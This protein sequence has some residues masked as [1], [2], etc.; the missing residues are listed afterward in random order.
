MNDWNKNW[1][2]IYYK[3]LQEMSIE[4]MIWRNELVGNFCSIR[5]RFSEGE[6]KIFQG[7]LAH[8]SSFFL[9]SPREFPGAQNFFFRPFSSKKILRV[10][11]LYYG[12]ILTPTGSAG[13]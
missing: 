1:N 11:R 10:S 8:G 13:F 7:F 9:N 12:K 3:N 5:R 4:N 6:K 2:A